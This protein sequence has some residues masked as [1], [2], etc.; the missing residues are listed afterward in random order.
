MTPLTFSLKSK[1]EFTLDVSPLTPDRLGS[2]S[3]D[4]IKSLKLIYGKQKSSV[5][6]LFKVTGKDHNHIK[7]TNSTSRVISIGKEMSQG[8]IEVG[9]DVGKLVGQGMSD[10]NITVSGSVGDWMGNAMTG[11]RIDIQGNAGDF[12]GAS[13][14]GDKFGMNRGFINIFGDA[15]DRIGDRMRRGM[16]IIHGNANNFCGSRMYAG[17][18]IVMGKAGKNTG[19]GMRRGSLVLA[20]KPA[21]ISPTFMSCGNLKMQ[22]LRL[23]F[24][25]LANIGDEF[26]IFRKIGPEAHRFSGDRARN[27][28]GE[29]LLLQTLNTRK[30]IK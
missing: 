13:L 18:I 19:A 29:I 4:K 1:P 14:P 17:T 27:G 24:T 5:S 2:L 16:I 10:G 11:G 30:Q 9:G 8:L 12:V 3:L 26:S 23:L 7:I 20:K 25:Q 21:H 15:G 6:D 28:Q 22:F